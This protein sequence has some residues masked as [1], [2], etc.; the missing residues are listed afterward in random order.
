MY[1]LVSVCQEFR[2]CLSGW[3]WLR[4]SYKV[5][6]RMLADTTASFEDLSRA[7]EPL[8]DE[9]FPQLLAGGLSSL[10]HGLLLAWQLASS[11]ENYLRESDRNRVR[12]WERE[13]KQE[14]TV[15]FISSFQSLTITSIHS[16]HQKRFTQST[17]AHTQEKRNYFPST[18]GKNIKELVVILKP[19]QQY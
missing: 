11:R 5:V 3:L 6:D 9:S 12:E 15:F 10:L 14:V 13:N 8:P 2:S 1:Y 16:F 17:P 7:E 4:A 18:E 19:S